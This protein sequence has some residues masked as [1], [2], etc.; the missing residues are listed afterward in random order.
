MPFNF[1]KKYDFI[2][3]YNINGTELEV[4]YEA[5]LLG[6]I[7]RSDCKWSS[8]TKFMTNKAKS[9]LWF[10]RRI[11]Y[12][13]AS[14]ETQLDLYKLYVRSAVEM[15]APLWTGSLN[16]TDIAA[17]ERVQKNSV[18][19]ILGNQYRTYDEALKRLNL[20]TLELR[21]K[22]LCL[23]FARKTSKNENFKHWFPKKS[24]LNTRSKEIYIEP[25]FKTKRY[26]KSSIPHLINLLN[27]DLCK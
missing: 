7:I 2:P 5:K 3:S 10:L 18:K 8:N 6:I 26:Q 11:K 20:D 21:R 16:K 1:T 9:R 19:F 12:L 27:E 17:I 15:A 13:G 25:T 22:K 23:K 14:I 4:V 24:S